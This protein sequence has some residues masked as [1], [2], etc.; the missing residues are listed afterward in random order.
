MQSQSRKRGRY[1]EKPVR[2][3]QRRLTFDELSIVG[4]NTTPSADETQ[5]DATE[6]ESVEGE[7]R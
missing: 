3:L 7:G 4:E 2:I 1:E 6:N 5:R